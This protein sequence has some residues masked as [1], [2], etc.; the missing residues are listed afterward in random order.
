MT[1]L[2]SSILRSGC[3]LTHML[4]TFFSRLIGKRAHFGIWASPG[5]C[6]SCWVLSRFQP[7]AT[8]AY[9]LAGSG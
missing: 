5:R 3:L 9:V 8:D 2:F 7:Q 6:M 1:T 4:S